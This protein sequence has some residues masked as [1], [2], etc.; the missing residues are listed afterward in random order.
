VL[1]CVENLLS[2]NI[3]FTDGFDVDVEWFSVLKH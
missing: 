1:F 2:S 3:E